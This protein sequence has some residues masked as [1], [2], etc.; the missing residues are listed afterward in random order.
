M[1]DKYVAEIT[2]TEQELDHASDALEYARNNTVL[3]ESQQKITNL[4]E[5][6]YDAKNKINKEKNR[7]QSNHDCSEQG[8]DWG[9]MSVHEDAEIPHLYKGCNAC[10]TLTYRPIDDDTWT[11][12]ENWNEYEEE[13]GRKMYIGAKRQ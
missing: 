9:K 1:T 2:L 12:T 8:H 3:F 6:I 13:T 10:P 11:E 5:K 7:V 4:K